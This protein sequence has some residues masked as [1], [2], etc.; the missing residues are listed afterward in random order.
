MHD[1]QKIRENP[2]N[3]D[4]QI[5]KRG[6]LPVSSSILAIDKEKRILLTNIQDL[7]NERRKLSEK[8]GSKKSSTGGKDIDVEGLINKVHAIKERINS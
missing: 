1:I 2:V 3:F 8:I 7:Q 5:A 4:N 6:I